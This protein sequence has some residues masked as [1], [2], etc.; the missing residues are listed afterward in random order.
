MRTELICRARRLKGRPSRQRR[1]RLSGALAALALAAL[2]VSPEG[3]AQEAKGA[4][5]TIVSIEQADLIVD[6]GSLTGATQGTVV[7]LWRPVRLRHPI[8]GR[9][10]I[11]R[12]RLGQLRLVQV[13]R[14]LSI[15][16]AEG[17]LSRAAA[18]GDVVVLPEAKKPVPA[19]VGVQDAPKVPL[20]PAASEDPEEHALSVLFTSLKGKDPKARIQAYEDYDLDSLYQTSHLP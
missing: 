16:R 12:F 11:D 18:T 9:V 2:L 8:T 5:S 3:L 20:P 17:E 13:Q 4:E 6:T 19:E 1:A 14:T 7:E 10:L 15:A